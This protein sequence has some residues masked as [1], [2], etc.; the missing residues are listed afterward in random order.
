[1]RS[2][3]EHVTPLLKGAGGSAHR[4]VLLVGAIDQPKQD[5]GV[6]LDEHQSWSL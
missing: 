4:C 5:S 6:G 1:L 2:G 3:D